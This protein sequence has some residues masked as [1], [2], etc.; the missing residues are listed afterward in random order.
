VHHRLEHL[1]GDDRRLPRLAGDTH[2]ALLHEG[3]LLE[4]DLHAEVSP[5]EHDPV[6]RRHDVCKLP[7]RLG[8]LDLGDHRGTRAGLVEDPAH[9]SDVLGVLDEGESHQVH[10]ERHGEAKV[11]LVLRRERRHVD[12]D[13]GQGYAL[14]VAHLPALDDLA[15]DLGLVRLQDGEREVAVVDEQPVAG[16]H[17][18]GEPPEVRRDLTGRAGHV[19]DGDDHHVARLPQH[20]TVREGAETDLR[21]LQVGEDGDRSTDLLGGGPHRGVAAGM[22]LVA[23]V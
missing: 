14:V 2:R 7:D 1:G 5:G 9:R 8:L 19:V 15:E 13:A 21:P 18:R 6:E 12:L 16:A 10:P 22:L 3:D 23:S 4:R 20:R 17:G 11:L